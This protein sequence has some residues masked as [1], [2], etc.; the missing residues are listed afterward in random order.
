MFIF[1]FISFLITAFIPP[2][3]RLYL[4]SAAS[5]AAQMAMLMYKSD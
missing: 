4:S 5:E 1:M 2:T 3:N